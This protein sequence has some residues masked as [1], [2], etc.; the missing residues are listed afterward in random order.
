VESVSK[1][2]RFDPW[3]CH[4]EGESIVL[5]LDSLATRMDVFHNHFRSEFDRV[6]TVSSSFQ[7]VQTPGTT[8]RPPG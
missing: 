4:R 5:T 7:L 3:L 1:R 2:S 6:Y 8:S